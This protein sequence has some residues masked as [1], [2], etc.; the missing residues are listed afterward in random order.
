MRAEGGRN[1][2]YMCEKGGGGRGRDLITV[3]GSGPYKT[4]MVCGGI[5]RQS[6]ARDGVCYTHV[7]AAGGLAGNGQQSC[8][9]GGWGVRVGK[10][11]H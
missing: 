8:V 7:Y 3:Y 10:A 4:I 5:K 2:M 6:V 9:G 11:G 1:N